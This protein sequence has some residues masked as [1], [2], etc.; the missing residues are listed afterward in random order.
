M[1]IGT[2]TILQQLLSDSKLVFAPSLLAILQATTPPSISDLMALPIYVS[3]CWG[4]YLLVLMKQNY[5]PRTYIGSATNI[6][7]GLGKRLKNYDAKTALPIYVER[8]LNEGYSIVFKGLLCWC[9]VPAAGIKFQVCVLLLALEAMF[10]FTLWAMKSR[11]KDYGLPTLC[12][13]SRE[14][15]EYDGCCGHNLLKESVHGE[16]DGLNVKQIAVKMKEIDERNQAVDGARATINRPINRAANLA[17]K[18]YFC[19]ICNVNCSDS[20]ELKRHEL[21]EKHINAAAGIAQVLTASGSRDKVYRENNK[22][23]KKYH[24]NPCNKTLD[25]N[26]KLQRHNR[27]NM[28]KAAVARAKAAKSSSMLD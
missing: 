28:H 22:A 6:S 12:P 18:K 19:E 7:G 9:P 15:I 25:V 14:S 24:C 17:A 16:E 5:R 11:T 8:A 4:V 27:S 20:A 1:V 21:S 3:K 26:L 13:W 10:S 23:T 2:Q